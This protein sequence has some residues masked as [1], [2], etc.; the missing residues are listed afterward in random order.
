LSISVNRSRLLADFADPNQPRDRRWWQDWDEAVAAGVACVIPGASLSG[1]IEVLYV[2]GLGDSDPA[3][4]FAGLV[5]DGRVGLLQPGLPTNSIDGA[6]AAALATDPATW[7]SVL[8]G[9]PGDA[10]RDVSQVVTGDPTR[11]GNLVG[12]DQT[13]RAPASALVTALWP[14]L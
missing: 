4:L 9:I 1:P 3:E 13:Q 7:W 11:L 12:G 10:D 8:T 2:V 14:A 6:P 5:A